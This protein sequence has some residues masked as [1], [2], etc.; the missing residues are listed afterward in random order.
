MVSVRR[1]LS[2]EVSIGALIS[3]SLLISTLITR[4]KPF[5]DGSRNTLSE[6]SISIVKTDVKLN[7]VL[8]NT[9]SSLKTCRHLT[10][11]PFHNPRVSDLQIK[12]EMELKLRIPLH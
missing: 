12:L 11:L 4:L 6:G 2:F 10:I 7:M 8:E 9:G 3:V 5:Y 1:C